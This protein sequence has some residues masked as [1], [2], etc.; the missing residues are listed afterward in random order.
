[1]P[2][3]KYSRVSKENLVKNQ[4]AR[5]VALSFAL[6]GGLATSLEAASYVEGQHYIN[7]AFIARQENQVRAQKGDCGARHAPFQPLKW[8]WL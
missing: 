7:A 1:M 8:R 2:M 3:R 4:I 5:L 6:V